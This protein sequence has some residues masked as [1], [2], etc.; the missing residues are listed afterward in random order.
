VEIRKINAQVSV[1]GQI[2]AQELQQIADAGFKMIINNRPDGEA[3][4]QPSNGELAEVAESLGLR[5]YHLPVTMKSMNSE[6]AKTLGELLQRAAG[7]VLAFC[8][9]GRRSSL[10][11]LMSLLPAKS[12][13]EVLEYARKTGLDTEGLTE[14]LKFHGHQ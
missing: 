13:S 7:P 9:S 3:P 11:Y 1:S 14:F 12:I 2:Q 5:W 10:L 6:D 8:R 4:G